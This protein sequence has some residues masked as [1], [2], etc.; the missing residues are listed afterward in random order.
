MP[1]VR[2]LLR[3]AT[4]AQAKDLRAAISY[5][6]EAAAVAPARPATWYELGLLLERAGD[7]AAA[8][9]AYEKVIGLNPTHRRATDALR[10]IRRKVRP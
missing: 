1:S 8:S 6:E 4:Y 9:K 2:E 3:K 10:R 7:L 5:L